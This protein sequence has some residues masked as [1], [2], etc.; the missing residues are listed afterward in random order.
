MKNDTTTT[1]LNFIL[2]ALVILG[3]LFALL[4]IWKGRDARRIQAQVQYQAMNFQTAMGRAQVLL[5]DT[6]AYNASAKS[7][8]LAAIIQS[9]QT[10]A[11]AVK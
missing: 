6:I 3:V 4:G 1:T 7:P 2:A 11:P 5:N 9:V 8:E 10:P